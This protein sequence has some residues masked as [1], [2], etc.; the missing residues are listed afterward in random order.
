MNLFVHIGIFHDRRSGVLT[1][2]WVV[3]S[4]ALVGLGIA[5]LGSIGGGARSTCTPLDTL[6]TDATVAEMGRIDDMPR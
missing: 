4:A 1:V 2:D 6:L 5:V 3:L